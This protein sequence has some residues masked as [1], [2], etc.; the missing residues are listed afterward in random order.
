[1]L[2][3]WVAQEPKTR[4]LASVRQVPADGKN[5]QAARGKQA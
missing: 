2:L 5:Q 3:I 4:R 1:V